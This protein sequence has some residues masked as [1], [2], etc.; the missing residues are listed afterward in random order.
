MFT[1]HVRRGKS[2]GKKEILYFLVIQ[3]DVIKVTILKGKQTNWNMSCAELL[4]QD[5]KCIGVNLN[6]TTD[7]A[8]SV[9]S[10]QL[11]SVWKGLPVRIIKLRHKTFNLVSIKHML[12]RLIGTQLFLHLIISV[13]QNPIREHKFLGQ[14]ESYKQRRSGSVLGSLYYSYY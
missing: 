5:H 2:G 6:A 4:V 3:F 7:S 10:V 8:F 14:E 1:S 13:R 9:A 12:V 11:S